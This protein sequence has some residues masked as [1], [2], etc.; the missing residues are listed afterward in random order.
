MVC[1]PSLTPG[2]KNDS[3]T[4]CLMCIYMAMSPPDK[5]AL[6]GD[7]RSL[8]RIKVQSGVVTLRVVILRA[9]I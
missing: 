5:E 4:S 7:F 9:V 8:F 1:V 6:R 2:G 3:F